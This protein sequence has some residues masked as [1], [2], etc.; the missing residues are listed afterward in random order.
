MLFLRNILLI[1]KTHQKS[2]K[3]SLNFGRKNHSNTTL[4]HEKSYLD[5]N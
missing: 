2:I 3:R 1:L 5:F 4:K